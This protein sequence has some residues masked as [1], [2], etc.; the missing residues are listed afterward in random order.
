M[1]TEWNDTGFTQELEALIA[2]KLKEAGAG[3]ADLAKLKAPVDTGKLRDSIGYKVKGNTVYVF[4]K[5]YAWIFNEL[6]TAEMKP[7]PFLVPA[8]HQA[9]R[10]LRRVLK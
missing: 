4:A 9:T 3:I 1:I 10:I 2:A 6:G 5:D 7:H 8:L